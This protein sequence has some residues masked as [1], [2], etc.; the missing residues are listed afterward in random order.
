MDR[1]STNTL[2]MILSAT[3]SSRSHFC[4]AHNKSTRLANVFYKFAFEYKEKGIYRSIS[5]QFNNNT[6]KETASLNCLRW[7]RRTTSVVQQDNLALPESTIHQSSHECVGPQVH[8]Y[9]SLLLFFAF[10]GRVCISIHNKWFLSTGRETDR[11]MEGWLSRVLFVIFLQGISWHDR[12]RMRK[13][14]WLFTIVTCSACQS[15]MV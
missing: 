4:R 15:T 11:V 5:M 8:G 2:I 6:Q 7:R 9:Q 10:S 12:R 3:S 1:R 13:E 14:G